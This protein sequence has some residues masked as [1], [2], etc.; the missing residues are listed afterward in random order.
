MFFLVIA[1]G[2]G[3]TPRTALNSTK[4]QVKRQVVDTAR[5]WPYYF[6]RLFPVNVSDHLLVYRLLSMEVDLNVGYV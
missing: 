2:Q 1:E 6:A 3:I 5:E 4:T